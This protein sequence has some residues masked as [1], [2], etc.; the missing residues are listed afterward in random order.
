MQENYKKRLYPNELIE[1]EQLMQSDGYSN[2]FIFYIINHFQSLF[3]NGYTYNTTATRQLK[4]CKRIG[5]ITYNEEQSRDSLLEHIED[6]VTFLKNNS[7]LKK[8]CYL[9]FTNVEKF[10]VLII[11]QL[12]NDYA[13]KYD[14]SDEE[15]ENLNK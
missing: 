11:E 7:E 1:I 9:F 8:E 15:L 6:I 14:Y 12:F 13:K 2:K 5:T 4:Y 10:E 3:E